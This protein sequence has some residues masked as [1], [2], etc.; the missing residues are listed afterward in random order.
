MSEGQIQNTLYCGVHELGIV[1]QN[2]P[3]LSEAI[4]GSSKILA[5]LGLK[6]HY[7]LDPATSALL[8]GAYMTY[9]DS[10]HQKQA[11]CGLLS[12][13]NFTDGEVL[14]RAPKR[15]HVDPVRL[16]DFSDYV[17]IYKGTSVLNQNSLLY[18]THLYRNIVGGNF[19]DTHTVNQKISR[20]N[21]HITT[22]GRDEFASKTNTSGYFHNYNIFLPCEFTNNVFF[23]ELAHASGSTLLPFLGADHRNMFCVNELVTQGLSEQVISGKRCKDLNPFSLYDWIR[24][25]FSQNLPNLQLDELIRH[26]L[27]D[28]T[29][30]CNSPASNYL[31][32]AIIN[33]FQERNLA[34]VFQVCR[35]YKPKGNYEAGITIPVNEWGPGKTYW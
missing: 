33:S 17:A 1:P 27:A 28:N 19:A 3:N 26:Y 31:V 16:Y 5:I 22:L 8:L 6:Q 32:R 12:R 34:R 9:K 18:P 15:R 21:I 4:E 13:P 30:A 20:C 23:H 29:H 24:S 14:K 2:Q 35:L 25:A 10:A 11:F 7:Y